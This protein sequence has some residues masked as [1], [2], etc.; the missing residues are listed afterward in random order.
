MDWVDMYMTDINTLW[1]SS[2]VGINRVLDTIA[3]TGYWMVHEDT[4]ICNSI[5]GYTLAHSVVQWSFR[6]FPPGIP[7]NRDL[8]NTI[9]FGLPNIGEGMG[10]IQRVVYPSMIDIHLG[11]HHMMDIE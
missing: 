4:M 10:E 3:H 5:Q 2:S 9:E 8:D 6:A 1:D 7:P 11:Y